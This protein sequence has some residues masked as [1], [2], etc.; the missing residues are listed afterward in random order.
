MAKRKPEF[1][2]EP[3]D[4]LTRLCDAMTE[5]LDAH[6]EKGD[7]KCVVFLDSDSE[8]RGGIQTHGY[9]DPTDAIV[10]LFIHLRAMFQ[11]RGGDL[12]FMPMPGGPPEQN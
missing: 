12:S 8:Q 1:T 4:R 5:A 7:A 3:T 9:E 2:S 11:A 10:N 6:P